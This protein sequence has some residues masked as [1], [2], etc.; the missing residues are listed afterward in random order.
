[1]SLEIDMAGKID[2]QHSD[3]KNLLSTH[4]SFEMLSHHVI[5]HR[6]IFYC[7]IHSNAK[8]SHNKKLNKHH[9]WTKFCISE[10]ASVQFMNYIVHVVTILHFQDNEIIPEDKAFLKQ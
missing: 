8:D 1:M 9:D 2:R 10:L 7:Q 5:S 3:S 6:T 4:T